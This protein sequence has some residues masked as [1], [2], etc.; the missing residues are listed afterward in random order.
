MVDLVEPNQRF[1]LVFAKIPCIEH[2]EI[3]DYEIGHILSSAYGCRNK[4]LKAEFK[5][6]KGFNVAYRSKDTEKVENIGIH[7]MKSKISISKKAIA[8]LKNVNGDAQIIVNDYYAIGMKVLDMV[9]LFLLQSPNI[10]NKIFDKQL[11][12]IEQFN[13][14][15]IQFMKKMVK[16]DSYDHMQEVLCSMI[17][18]SGDLEK[19]FDNKGQ[20]SPEKFANMIV[21]IN[22]SIGIDNCQTKYLRKEITHDELQE[23]LRQIVRSFCKK[24]AVWNIKTLSAIFNGKTGDAKES[25]LVK[26]DEPKPLVDI[27]NEYHKDSQNGNKLRKFL[28]KAPIVSDESITILKSGRDLEKRRYLKSPLESFNTFY[29]ESWD[30]DFDI[31]HLEEIT[32]RK[33]NEIKKPKEYRAE[34]YG[35][36]YTKNWNHWCQPAKASRYMAEDIRDDMSYK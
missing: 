11:K 21:L 13:Y 30:P 1:D 18:N 4:F 35:K 12:E 17:Y 29:F 6:F 15:D 22:N 27:L 32:E 14:D 36:H 26:F 5:R 19:T 9:K 8:R 34:I 23:S 10:S 16:S 24:C 7:V 31:D 25:T 20:I 2:S 28:L 33:F 3:S